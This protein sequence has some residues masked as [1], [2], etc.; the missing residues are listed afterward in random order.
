[1]YLNRDEL[2]LLSRGGRVPPATRAGPPRPQPPGGERSGRRG[3]RRP[4]GR[5]D[6]HGSRGPGAYARRDT[7]V[8]LEFA[9]GFGADDEQWL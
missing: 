4:T 6:A 8:E 1:M 5:R 3:W 2:M 9:V 7:Y